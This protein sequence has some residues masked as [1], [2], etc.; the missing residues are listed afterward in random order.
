MRP[1]RVAVALVIVRLGRGGAERVL[2][3]IANGLDPTRYDVHVITI[4][5]RGELAGELAPYVTLHVLDRRRAWD[6]AAFRRF[7]RVVAEN[8]IRVVHTHSHL[9][10]YFVSMARGP[11]RGRWL[12]VVHEHY[13]LIRQSPLRWADRLCLSRVDHWFATSRALAEYASW[14]GIPPERCEVL[15]NGT[16]VSEAAERDRPRVFTIAQLGRVAPQKNQ[17]MALAVAA[18]LQREGV[19]FRWLIIGRA[20]SAYAEQC[21]RE[22]RELGLGEAVRFTGE[23]QDPRSTLRAASVGVLTSAAEALPLALLEYMAEGLPVVATDV[24]DVGAAVSASGGG[25]VVRCG[26]APGF[27][28]A[29]RDYASDPEAA[30][31]AGEANRR[32]VRGHHRSGAMV[33]RVAEVYAELV[34]GPRHSSE[35]DSRPRI[36]FLVSSLESGIGAA[37]LSTARHLGDRYRLTVCEFRSEGSASKERARSLGIQ[38]IELGKRGVN[39]SIVFD[40][41]VVASAHR[42]RLV[43]GFELETNFYAC[44]VGRV[45]GARVVATFHGMVS[46]FRRSRR[47]ALSLTLRAADRIVSVSPAIGRRCVAHAGPAGRRLVVIPNGVDVPPAPASRRDGGAPLTVICVANLYS[48][49]KGHAVLLRAMALLG[50]GLRLR[51]VGDGDLRSELERLTDRLHLRDRVSFLGRRDDV[52]ELLAESDVFVLPSFSEGCP[53][54][55]LEAMMAGLPVVA[56][57]V[58]GVREVV[59]DRVTG[60]LVPPGDPSALARV[61]ETLAAEPAL[62]DELGTAA[63][64]EAAASFR[65]DVTAKRYKELYEALGVGAQAVR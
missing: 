61:L 27:A 5:D 6:V 39:P 25:R 10:A 4:R 28:A 63:R 60:L 36:L 24:G 18:R 41:L 48:P 29:L 53:M 31:R 45:V 16:D 40:L 34:A 26:D 44:L 12:H 43:Q 56:S 20:D 9:A 52:G 3:S 30:V 65:A 1:D 51:L 35:L 50:A 57:G 49:L 38:V 62:R 21:R 14:V 19:L 58:G 22:A 11:R 13:P 15:A 32:Y 54:A 8:G 55:L 37:L 46:A 7:R 23:H 59:R 17:G 42:P 33:Q 47:P 2:V 64:R